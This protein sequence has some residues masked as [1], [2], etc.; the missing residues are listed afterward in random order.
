M[1]EIAGL[2]VSGIGLIKDLYTLHSDL[3]SWGNEDLEVD[4]EWLSLALANDVL[5]GAETEY[6]WA[7]LRRVP[8]LELKGS[9][10]V[11]ASHN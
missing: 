2:V 4:R 10:E 3:G 1:L 9:H 11:V 6:S 5:S 7:Q 8:T